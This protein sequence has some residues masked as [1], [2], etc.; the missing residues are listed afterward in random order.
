MQNINGFA[1]WS[2]TD[3]LQGEGKYTFSL[4]I[5]VLNLYYQ[6][7]TFEK[8]LFENTENIR[9]QFQPCR[10]V[11]IYKLIRSFHKL[12]LKIFDNFSSFGWNET[13]H[14]KCNITESLCNGLVWAHMADTNTHPTK[15]NLINVTSLPLNLMDVKL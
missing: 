11:K 1:M 7:K 8:A 6:S 13:L 2:F 14:L 9:L 12:F 3:F 4:R 10:M 15:F 5:G